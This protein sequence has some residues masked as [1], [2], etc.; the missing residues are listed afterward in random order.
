MNSSPQGG[1]SITVGGNTGPFGL[2]VFGIDADGSTRQAGLTLGNA[3]A[4]V[5]SRAFLDAFPESGGYVALV[6]ATWGNCWSK[7]ATAG[8]SASDE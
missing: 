8:I 1:D 3:D 5:Q 6:Q 2:T 4:D 7:M